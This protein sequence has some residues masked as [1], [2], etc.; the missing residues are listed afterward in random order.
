MLPCYTYEVMSLKRMFVRLITLISPSYNA[1]QHRKP[2]PSA[3]KKFVSN[4]EHKLRFRCF[5]ADQQGIP[6]EAFEVPVYLSSM[7]STLGIVSQVCGPGTAE[8]DGP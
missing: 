3:H 5:R 6:E 4:L 8:Y 2:N 1:Q 7:S